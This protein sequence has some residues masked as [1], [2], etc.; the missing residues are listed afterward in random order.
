[1]QDFV[2]DYTKI[3]LLYHILFYLFTAIMPIL[4]IVYIQDNVRI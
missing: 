3:A 1:M 4:E 2:S